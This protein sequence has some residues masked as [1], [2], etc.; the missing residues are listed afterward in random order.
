MYVGF[1]GSGYRKMVEQAELSQW[2]MARVLGMLTGLKDSV[3][4]RMED[5]ENRQ[6]RKSPWLAALL[7]SADCIFW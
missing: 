4:K 3:A 5:G 7:C 6:A 2:G 1:F